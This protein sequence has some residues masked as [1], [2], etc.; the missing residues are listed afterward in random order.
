MLA[1]YYNLW[2]LSDWLPTLQQALGGALTIVGVIVVFTESLQI[3]HAILTD[4]RAR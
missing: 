2:G 4:K 3:I 1:L